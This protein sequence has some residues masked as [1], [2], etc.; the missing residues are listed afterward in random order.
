[1]S[2]RKRSL[3]DNHQVAPKLAL[4]GAPGEVKRGNV[5][6]SN[7]PTAAQ[8]GALKQSHVID[9]LRGPPVPQDDWSETLRR[10]RLHHQ[11]QDVKCPVRDVR[12]ERGAQLFA[13]TFSDFIQGRRSRQ[14]VGAVCA[15]S[16]PHRASL[17][18]RNPQRHVGCGHPALC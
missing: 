12:M 6:V 13:R 8:T 3:V 5:T 1:M 11:Q 15:K 4:S 7:R 16:V 18:A 14:F 10:T 9:F 2:G 17:S